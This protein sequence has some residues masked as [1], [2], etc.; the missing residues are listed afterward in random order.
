MLNAEDYLLYYQAGT[1]GSLV[2]TGHSAGPSVTIH[3]N[4]CPVGLVP[5]TVPG[6]QATFTV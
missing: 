2:S 3:D 1:R 4:S 5:S 6:Y